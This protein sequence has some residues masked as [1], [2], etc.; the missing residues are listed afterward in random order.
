MQTFA[1]SFAGKF[2][3]LS[4]ALYPKFCL[5]TKIIREK[6][7]FYLP[8]LFGFRYVVCVMP[9]QNI[10]FYVRRYQLC[11]QQNHAISSKSHKWLQSHNYSEREQKSWESP[12]PSLLFG[13]KWY[14]SFHPIDSS[15]LLLA[16]SFQQ[17]VKYF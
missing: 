16:T 9:A 11:L 7:N 2:C 8:S 14:T 3:Q 10:M 6:P 17:I 13:A 12:A 1:F 5:T 4:H 15:L